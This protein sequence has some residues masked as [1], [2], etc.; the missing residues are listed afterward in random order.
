MDI[1]AIETFL[2]VTKKQS[3]S[4]AAEALYLTQP[5][6]S[7]RIA[8]LEAELDCKLFDR[9][10]KKIILTEAGRLFL[11]RAQIIV[12]ELKESKSALAE[13]GGLVSGELLMATS[14]HIGL[15]HL[16][17]ILKHYVNQYPNVDLKLDFMGSEAACRAVENAEIELAV[18]TLPIEPAPCLNLFTVWQDP[19]TFAIHNNHPL[20]ENT[21]SKGINNKEFINKLI[22]FPAILTEKKTYTRKLLDTYFEQSQIT[23]QVKLSNNYLETIKMMVSVGL[24]WSILPQTLIDN[25]VTAVTIPGFRAQRAL[26]IVTHKNT[27]HSHAAKKM[28]HLIT[29][30]V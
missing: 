24:G 9:I 12:Q 4:L 30:A 1:P 20:L 27:T 29:Q 7:K 2:I 26:G 17:P 13:M 16:P 22:K 5:A 8:A 15:H 18:I 10:K 21:Q 3:F 23:P 25:S 28:M 6:I 14:H 11:P 19:L